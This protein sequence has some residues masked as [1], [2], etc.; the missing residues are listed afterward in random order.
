[1]NTLNNVEETHKENYSLIMREKIEKTPFH[2]IGDEEKG[3]F[4]AL[5][6]YR[7]TE[8]TKTPEEAIQKLDIEKWNILVDV[9]TIIITATDNAISQLNENK[10]QSSI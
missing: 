10:R 9:I 1:M 3:Y 6:K 5:G 4:I 8:P 7:V 2:I